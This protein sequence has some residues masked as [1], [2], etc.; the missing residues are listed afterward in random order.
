MN[1]SKKFQLVSEVLDIEQHP[2]IDMIIE[3]PYLFYYVLNEHIDEIAQNGIPCGKDGIMAFFTRI[4]EIPKFAQFHSTHKP[5][6]ISLS[7]VKKVSG[8]INIMGHNFPKHENETIPLEIKDLEILSKKGHS[9]F[10]YFEQATDLTKI[11]HARV[12]CSEGV[13]PA[14]AF[15]VIGDQNNNT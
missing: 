2:N 1:T 3:K 11:P 10:K 15:K 4:P 14:F 9:F 12:H 8:K 5:A 6:K 13:L 7:K